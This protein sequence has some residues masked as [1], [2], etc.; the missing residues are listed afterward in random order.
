MVSIYVETNKCNSCGTY[1]NELCFINICAQFKIAVVAIGTKQ[2]KKLFSLKC[3]FNSYEILLKKKN[4]KQ[5]LL[6]WK[7]ENEYFEM[8]CFHFA[9]CS[10]CVGGF[11]FNL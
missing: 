1:V 5:L 3:F 9:F 2:W 8:G 11:F 10:F 7:Q 4:S 6:P